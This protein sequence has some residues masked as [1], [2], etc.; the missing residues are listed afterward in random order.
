MA[1]RKSGVALIIVAI[2]VFL[3]GGTLVAMGIER[4]SAAS[5]SEALADYHMK[6][7]REAMGGN[8]ITDEGATA[9]EWAASSA[10]D[11]NRQRGEGYI[12]GGLGAVLVL[13]SVAL[14]VVG[15]RQRRKPV[16]SA[17]SA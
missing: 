17:P 10:Q 16:P 12:W 3:G 13:G 7:G 8:S 15:L 2:V 6:R 14:F 11:A 1:G 4:F 9:M 5:E